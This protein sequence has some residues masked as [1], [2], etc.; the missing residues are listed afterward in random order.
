[1]TLHAA[2][3]LEFPVVFIA[4]LEQGILPHSRSS[5]DAREL[6]EERRLLFVGITRAERELYLSHCRVREFRGQRQATLP[7]SFLM[8]LPE[9]PMIIR[10][11]SGILSGMASSVPWRPAPRSV[12]ATSPREFRLSTA[13]ALAGAPVAAVDPNT[14]QPGIAVL[15]PKYGVGRI[16]AI[17]GA[18][19]NRKGRVAFTLGGER[20][21]VL[22]QSPLRPMSAR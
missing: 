20:T 7:S 16:V 17:E 8:E 4:G 18:G 2:K 12:A 13:A 1:M 22:A 14:F 10:D 15:H 11:V 19:P 9:E 3:G 6:E 21:F 5:E